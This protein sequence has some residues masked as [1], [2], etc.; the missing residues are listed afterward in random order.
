MGRLKFLAQKSSEEPG[1]IRI[2][3][4]S[5]PQIV[6]NVVQRETDPSLMV[7]EKTGKPNW[8]GKSKYKVIDE[9]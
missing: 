8:R 9:R 2:I 4:R 1:H 6:A 3:E 5:P 7:V